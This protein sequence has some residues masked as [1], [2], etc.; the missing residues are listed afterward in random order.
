MGGWVGQNYA[1]ILHQLTLPQSWAS[2]KAKSLLNPLQYISPKRSVATNSKVVSCLDCSSPTPVI[3]VSRVTLV[4]FIHLRHT[5]IWL[6]MFV[7]NALSAGLSLT[8]K[9]L[10][11]LTSADTLCH[12]TLS[13]EMVVLSLLSS[14]S[15]S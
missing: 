2:L 10:P 11:K 3:L 14:S 15:S 12:R 13:L 7:W 6:A 4:Q 8:G 9:L 5:Y 1:Q